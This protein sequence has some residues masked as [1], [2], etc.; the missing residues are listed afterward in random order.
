VGEL[1]SA[2]YF[3]QIQERCREFGL[4]SGGHLLMEE[5]LVAHVPFYGDFFRCA[6]RLDAPGIDCLTSVPSEVPWYIARMLASAAELDGRRIVMSETS[7]HGQVWRP[8]GDLRPKRVV[9]EA[10]IRGTCNRLIVSGVN[11]ITSYYSFGELGDEALRRLNEWVG[12]CCTS[13]AGGHQ[14]AE[15]ALLYPVESIWPK[16]HPARHWANDSPGA[17]AIENTW[18]SAMD[19][20]F[21]AQQDFTVID[22]RTLAE[23]KVDGGALVHGQLRW[24]VLVLPGVDT[25]PQAAWENLARF[26]R[27]G[28]VVIA[29]GALPMNSETEFPS[30][31][32]ESLARNVFGAVTTGYSVK[33]D[34]AGG[35]GIFLPAGTEGLLPTL[36]D[37]V[38][39]RNVTVHAARS[40]VRAT[41]RRIDGR[42][43]YF[44]V[45]DSSKAWQGEVSLSV[46]G[47]GERWDP[48]A[49]AVAQTNLGPRVSLKLE[50]YGA[51]LLRYPSAQLAQTRKLKSDALP[52]L[53][54]HP[55]PDVK[56]IMIQGEFVRAELTRDTACS[57]PG[58]PAWRASAVLTRSQVDTFMFLRF[59]FPEPIDL[60]DAKYLV[61]DTWVPEG[62]Q[63]GNQLLAIVQEKG[64]GD[65]LAATGRS[66]GRPGHQRV[67]VPLSGL[68][69][70]GWS[71]D[72]DGELDL[73]R[74]SEIRIGWGGYLGTEGERLEFSAALPQIGSTSGPGPAMSRGQ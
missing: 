30:P 7:D 43:V 38:L 1:V 61:L 37:G 73:K 31:T 40:P 9:T 5:G 41:H 60:S 63:T 8:L 23:A 57:K 13:L 54:Q 35:G 64:G 14:V 32:V 4:P 2:N 6:R 33:S 70:A 11:A 10:E 18:H 66:L 69:L 68:Q 58:S 16:F 49:T 19:N 59:S 62:Q 20:L 34:K 12:R 47:A 67:F 22:S 71:K 55:V 39:E 28:G 36:L 26:V 3:G 45:N 74:V 51:A 56:P 50:P 52:H 44:L 48:A 65:F 27:H 15:V 42:E 72:D 24:H 53:S 25:L 29:L 21:A 17:T 46:T